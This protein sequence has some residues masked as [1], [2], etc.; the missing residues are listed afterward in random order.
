VQR[1]DWPVVGLLAGLTVAGVGLPLCDA[2]MS[3][4]GEYAA[5]RYAA[6]AGLAGDLAAALGALDGRRSE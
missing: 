2:A 4:A 1:Q 5:D 6:A 3:R